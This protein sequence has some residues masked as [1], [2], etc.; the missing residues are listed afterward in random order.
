MANG[1]Q[2][3]LSELPKQAETHKVGPVVS[4]FHSEDH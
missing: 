2:P 3:P 1:L 4:V